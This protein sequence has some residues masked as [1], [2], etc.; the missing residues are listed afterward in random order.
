MAA[1]QPSN[2][3][4]SVKNKQIITTVALLT[5]LSTL[6]PQLS[7]AP[8]GTAFTY[9]GR[10]TDGANPASG[11]YDLRFTIYDALTNGTLKA[12]VTNASVA[13]TNG[14]FTTPV[15]FGLPPLNFNAVW[16]EIGVRTNGS[17]GDFTTVSPRQPLTPA[18]YAFYALNSSNAATAGAASNLLGVLP[19][20]QLA[21]V[22]SSALTFNNTG[23][24]FAG[25]GTGLT[26]VNAATLGGLGAVYFWQT[27][28]NSGTTAD[29]NFIG[30]TDNQPLEFR[31]NYARALRLEPNPFGPNMIGGG[32]NSIATGGSFIGGGFYN[33]IQ[34]NSAY[35]A[36]VGGGN[37]TI[38]TNDY[39]T[40]IAGGYTNTIQSSAYES[41]IGGG[42]FNVIQAYASGSAIG[43][44]DS[45]TNTA[46]FAT[47]PGGDQN[48]ASANAFA[49]GH[50]AKAGY[51]GDFVWADSTDADFAATGN[52]QF[53][54]RAANGV[55]IN[56]NNPGGVALNVNGAIVAT[57]FVGSGA[58][59][60]SLS[61]ASLTSGSVGAALNLTNTANT[62]AGNGAGLTN[63][64]ATN[65]TAGTLADARLSTNVALLNASQ[66]FS[67]VN[68]FTNTANTFAGNGAGVTSLNAT[69][70][71]AGT[72]PDARLA[73]NV[74]RTNQV[75]LL[76]GNTGT[77]AGVNYLGTTDN[78]PLELRVNGLRALR[79]EPN[80]GGPNV[81]GGSSDNSVSFSVAAATI[82]GGISNQV[83]A[84][85]STV[86]GGVQNVAGS[87]QG[88]YAT[89]G[90][91]EFNNA[92]GD[93][94]VIGGGSRNTNA[95]Y[96]SV[97]G[98]GVYN[99]VNFGS[100]YATIAGGGGNTM[101]SMDDVI[102]GGLDNTIGTSA[103][104]SS[105]G[106][107]SF[108]NIA[109]GANGASI[110]GG[111]GNTNQASLSVIGGGYDNSIQANADHSFLGGGYDNSIQVNADHSFIGSGDYNSIQ[112]YADRSFIG[113]GYD[114]II[115]AS[116]DH[117]FI[118]GGE[119]NFIQPTSD[120]SFI[121]GGAD[122]S[123]QTNADFSFIGC[124]QQNII[125]TIANLSF[126][127]GGSGN[128]IQ[129][130]AAFSVL[131]GGSG[132]NIQANAAFSLLGGGQQNTIQ[133]NATNSVLGGGNGNVVSGT[134]GVVPGGDYNQAAAHSFAAGHYAQALHAGAFVWADFQNA[135][136]STTATNQ[137]LIRAAN[138]V[139]IN[140]NNPATALDVNGTVTATTFVGGRLGIGNSAPA[141]QLDVT[142]PQAVARFIATNNIY[143]SVLVLDN[144]TA[145]LTYH[146]AVNFNDG[147]GQISYLSSGAM[148]FTTS[149]GERMRI[150]SN[151]NVGVGNTNPGYLLVVG[152]AGSPAY[153]NGTTW[154]NG[155]DRDS[156]EA[157]AA[158]NPRTVL[159]KVS[160]LPITEWKYKAETDGTRHLGPVAQDFHAAFGLNGPDDK[161]IATVDEEGV[162]LAAIQG[163][164]QKLN[165]KDAEIQALKQSVAELK[166]TLTHLTQKPN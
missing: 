136:F 35:S 106:G 139:G 162:A 49:A 5:C 144:T 1:G 62:F 90:G 116:A 31:V 55:G 121:G 27:V 53:L 115:E 138:G 119:S 16:L 150:L 103:P 45:N 85:Y 99:L 89:V 86:G 145:G 158:I 38:Q 73:G 14:L 64:N 102:G 100:Q 124:G 155:S 29:I 131:G 78:Q 114:N 24:S 6:N 61:A 128:T 39:Y 41:F 96:V 143:G 19:T 159:E 108:N 142:A 70:L 2:K 165:E 52:N 129:A 67:G 17:A 123:I 82:G 26:N 137:F 92:G 104:D 147:A 20:A 10:L 134:L 3:E 50:R 72:V 84:N 101:S 28:G 154:V 83:V 126:I 141:F 25:N 161:H 98:G 30:T 9:Q 94:S 69:N 127:G 153:C 81:I 74:A 77:T 117:S 36:I 105:I 146:G 18:P 46:A 148:S 109:S 133:A 132:N 135:G 32:N 95:D 48:L 15:D 97:I 93:R 51:Q 57:N 87:G 122:N 107:G 21:G 125:Q 157:F 68:Q 63:L 112:P 34:T 11:G 120:H 56:T 8:L 42:R 59:L 43:G 151:G 44:G 152:S 79:L 60:T 75:W 110:G 149:S 40:V 4:K 12:V 166:E 111:V 66:T 113:G 164:N 71:A 140:K 23:N 65:L 76:N 13:V 47:I 22:Y 156:K 54:I 33:N 91:G 37:N 80:A 130:N 7:A 163:L 58:G 88:W 118:G 160:A